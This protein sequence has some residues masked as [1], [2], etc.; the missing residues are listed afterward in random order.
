MKGPYPK[1]SG[2]GFFLK[3]IFGPRWLE[4]PTSSS[5]IDKSK[6]MKQ[7]VFFQAINILFPNKSRNTA[8]H[9]RHLLK[10]MGA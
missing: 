7:E 4:F 6:L 1:V 5:F 8:R 3:K 9:I 10:P 2:R